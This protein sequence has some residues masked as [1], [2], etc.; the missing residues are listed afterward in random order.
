M[1]YLLY[2]NSIK[3]KKDIK[4][5]SMNLRVKLM[6]YDFDV[7]YVGHIKLCLS[8]TEFFFTD[9]QTKKLCRPHAASLAL[10]HVDEESPYSNGERMRGRDDGGI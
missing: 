10:L 9:R 6:I 2:T 5:A 8:K 3:L 7:Q 1:Q 4:N